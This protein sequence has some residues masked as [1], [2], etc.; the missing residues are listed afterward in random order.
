MALEVRA[1]VSEHPIPAHAVG[2]C[3]GELLEAGGPG[4]VAVVVAV[5]E[6]LIGALEDVVSATRQLL[7]PE[8]LLAV[9]VGGVVGGAREVDVGGAV[10]MFG[11]WDTEGRGAPV[12][13]VRLA[14]RSTPEGV[15]TDGLEALR[16]AEGTLVLFADPFSVDGVGLLGDLDLVAPALRVVGGE[17]SA[18]RFA[19]GNR[20][21]LDGATWT[22]GAVGLLLGAGA[23]DE[24]LI[25]RA[26][27]RVGPAMTVTAVSGTVG[28]DV[29]IVTGLAGRPA[30]ERLDE[31]LEALT[32]EDRSLAAGGVYLGVAADRHD[33]RHDGG[34][35]AASDQL[36]VLGMDA[37]SGGLAVGGAVDVGGAVRFEV[38][39]P[40]G[41]RTGADRTGRDRSGA[42][43][44]SVRGDVRGA[45]RALP[46]PFRRRR[47]SGRRG[48]GL[49][50]GRRC[51]GGRRVRTARRSE[52]SPD[53]EP[54]GAARRLSASAAAVERQ[55]ISVGSTPVATIAGS[56]HQEVGNTWQQQ[57]S[58]RG[59]DQSWSSWPSTSSAAWPW[60]RP[61]PHAPA[62]RARRW[63]WR[64][65]P[66]CCGP[67][68]CATTPPRRTGPTATASSCRA[69]HA[70]ILLY[71]MLYLTGYGL[72]LDDLKEFRQWGSATPGH[73]EVHHTAGV[74]VTTG[75]LGQG[76]ANAVG[77][78]IAEQSLRARFG[79][80][81]VDH[82]TFVHRRRR[83]T[84]RRA[85]ATRPRRSP[86][87]SASG[88]LVYVYD[89]N[90]ITIDGPTEL[91]LSDD[92]GE[93]FEAYGWHVI[94]VGEVG[95]RPR[96]P[97]GGA[98]RA[99][100]TSRTSRR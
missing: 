73:P 34:G 38:A 89:D 3:L 84:S 13:A 27:R 52:P 91:A 39:R 61:T 16:G 12:R 31:V 72:T 60:T 37:A 98:R 7:G 5:T 1:A 55:C 66:T 59:P 80:D 99:H 78:A 50:A 47:R 58:H 46:R 40:L 100:A 56:S 95:Q 83:L 44:R 67:G 32:L 51:R 30:R 42:R 33:D 41:G 82:H 64:R 81:V 25:S 9:T 69:G 18:A 45:W 14:T 92:A 96:R 74:E 43:H 88:R 10:M 71:S 48:D 26:V 65:W 36:P 6:A 93:R 53:L 90:H 2:T 63:R 21:V 24:P 15:R 75:P 17:L 76:F 62:T 20:L 19:G 8:A 54:G 35:E 86:A 85:S 4:P 68:S 97:R 57:R 49:P 77:M 11:V 79:A 28:D 94:E 29:T 87:T 23:A 22:D 70:S